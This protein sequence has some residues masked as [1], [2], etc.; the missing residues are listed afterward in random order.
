M[1]DAPTITDWISAISTS[2][3]GIA[4]AAITVWQ[5]RRGGFNPK[6]T[7]RVDAA[8]EGAELLIVNAGRA[9]GIIDRVTVVAKGGTV[10][11]AEF[12]GY[13]DGAFRPTA[14]PA[15]SSMRII[16]QAKDDF[17]DGFRLHVMAGASRVRRLAPTVERAGVGIFGLH[18]VLPPGTPT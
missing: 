1:A 11:E 8:H 2:A 13:K 17:P 14:L 7:S 3:L 16:I 5:W 15:M 18:S 9:A 12:E 4:G 10:I 6:L